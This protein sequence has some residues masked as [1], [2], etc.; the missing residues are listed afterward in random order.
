[1]DGR[2]VQWADLQS[3]TNATP[4]KLFIGA[5]SFVIIER[6]ERIGL[7]VRDPEAS[8]RLQFRGIDCFPYNPAWRV[9]GRFEPFAAP[10]TLRVQDVIGGTQE[11]PSPGTIIFHR[12]KMEHH[13]DVVEEPG[14]DEYFVIFRDLTAGKT[15]YAAGRFLYVARPDATGRVVVDFNRSYTPPCGFTPFSTCPLPPRQNWLPFSIRAGE[16]APKGDHHG[17]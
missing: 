6:G 11:F 15:T 4:T 1:V 14:E 13:L 12:G 3:D 9:E 8:S 10:R 16:R 7:R 2:Q 5:L 17:D